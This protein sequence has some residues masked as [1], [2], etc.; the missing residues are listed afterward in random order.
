MY[1]YSMYTYIYIYIYRGIYIELHYLPLQVHAYRYFVLLHTYISL[2]MCMCIHVVKY[3]CGHPILGDAN[4]KVTL[5]NVEN[6]D[7][8]RAVGDPGVPGPETPYG[9]KP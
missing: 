9:P 1:V 7:W 3:V 4:A 5:R 6:G 2:Y 8:Q